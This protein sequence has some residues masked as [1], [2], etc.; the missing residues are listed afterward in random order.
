MLAIP[1]NAFAIKKG[2]SC[3][4]VGTIKQTPDTTYK[5][6][7]RGKKL[8]WREKKSP[9]TQVFP[10]PSK[11]PKSPENSFSTPFP[12]NFTRFEMVEAV[13]ASFEDFFKTN[14]STKTFK[15]V[16]DPEFALKTIEIRAYVGKIYSALPFPTN[17]P[18]TIV[19]V[20]KN[21]NL[22][23]SELSSFGLDLSDVGP[24]WPCINCAGAGWATADNGLGAVTAHEI[25]H[26]WQKSAYNRKSNNAPDPSNPANPPTW[27]DEGSADLFGYLMYQ[28]ISR[29]YQDYPRTMSYWEPQ[30][31]KNYS[32]RNIDA[33]L[34]Y[35]LGRMA[36]EYIVASVGIERF[37][38]I[39]FNV[40]EGS[41]FPIAFERATG[42]S[43]D[44]FYEKFDK[45]VRKMF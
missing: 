22:V 17:Y 44:F 19:V 32:T 45:N 6:V 18:K 43:L 42:V 12:D 9:E 35:L 36:S 28:S 8:I 27:F 5:C 1:N 11:P 20:T 15:L 10:S 33:S 34:P 38:Q 30:P 37:L 25:F 23:K 21:R 29:T 7:K 3:K 2:D 24:N 14:S 4:K 41:D 26:I 16:V 31:L 39:F 13:K 40:G